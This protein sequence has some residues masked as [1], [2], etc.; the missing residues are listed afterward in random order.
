MQILIGIIIGLAIGIFVGMKLNKAEIN[1]ESAIA[2]LKSKG[3]I[4]RLYVGGEKK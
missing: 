3:Y 2:F 1:V 4:V